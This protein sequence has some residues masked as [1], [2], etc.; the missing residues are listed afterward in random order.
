MA[1]QGDATQVELRDYVRLFAR[2]KWTVFIAL[3]VVMG[4][5]LGVSFLK[6]P[7]Y[8][9]TAQILLQARST[10][11]LFD[12]QTG[13]RT[14]PN[15]AIQTEIQVL[16]SEPVKTAVREKLGVAPK[17]SA[18]PVAQTD[19]IQVKARSTRPD[20]AALVANT[21][22]QSYID[23][24]R[25][26]AVNDLLEAGQ[27]VQAK[28]ISLQADIDRLSS[29]IA[30]A[31]PRARAEAEAR[32]RPQLDTL[33]AQQ[34]LFKQRLDELQVDA[35]LKTGGAQLVTP[36]SVPDDPVEPR[37]KRTAVLAFV[38]GSLF[39]LGLAFLFDHLDDS[40]KTKDELEAVSG[41]L[42]VLGLIPSISNWK[43]RRQSM[44]ISAADPGS[45]A[46]EA[47]RSL[48]T[49]VQFLG[50]DRPVEVL[51][52]TSPNASEGKTTT[53]SNLAISLA[54]A[55]Q[56]VIV[57]CCD[58]RR[59]RLHQFFGVSNAVGF[60]SVLL[61]EVPL[62]A[63]LKRIRDE[64]YLRVLASGPLPPNPS[65]LLSSPRVAELVQALR[66]QADVVLFDAPPVLPVTDAAVLST[67]C[68]AAL[69]VTTANVTTKKQ[70]GR[71]IEVLQQ[72]DARIVGTVLNGVT[73]DASYGYGDQYYQSA[74]ERQQQQQ[75]QGAKPRHSA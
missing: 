55:G 46:A 49:S 39:A 45:P 29:Q 70:V 52:V 15:R 11:S 53:L 47:Y 73:A 57:V 65:E 67:Q 43:D 19:V 56:Q 5:S 10:D 3:G 42:P 35:A 24:R 48:R 72:V 1:G 40:I 34:S 17:I 9:G 66:R 23:F 33:V 6:T 60:T 25:R 37:P 41:G 44:L 74:P 31:D 64:D 51:L 20:R 61:G 27:E 2:R 50:L 38:V 69:L 36:A 18:A 75:R 14:D 12:P 13:A 54:R 62:S 16:K 4:T 58:L 68:D 22:A 8:Q 32:V 7:I 71:A 26:Q 30:V 59:P 21:Y 63:A 28:V